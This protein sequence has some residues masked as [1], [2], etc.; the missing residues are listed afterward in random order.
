[1]FDFFFFVRTV[2]RAGFNCKALKGLRATSKGLA[3]RTWPAGR[4][5]GTPVLAYPSAPFAVG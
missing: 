4:L 1:M 5:L 2:S 3:G